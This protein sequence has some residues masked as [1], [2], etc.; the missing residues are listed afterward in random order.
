MLDL[1]MPLIEA[2]QGPRPP[3]GPN[4]PKDDDERQ[5]PAQQAQQ[6]RQKKA[7]SKRR[8]I[9]KPTPQAAAKKKTAAIAKA[10]KTKARKAKEAT[11]AALAANKKARQE[12]KAA[13]A[14]AKQEPTGTKAKATPVGKAPKEMVPAQIRHCMLALKHKRGKSEKAAWNIC[15]WAMTKYGYLKGPYRVNTKLPK[16][17]RQTQ[18][19]VRRSFQHG[20]EKGPLNKGI[21][22]T[23]ITKARKFDKLFKKIEKDVVRKG[24]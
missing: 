16:A 12:K 22:G 7:A 20:M 8:T 4:P 19:G 23:G 14:A 24:A 13:R 1:L 18:K 5:E 9:K 6:K 17:T 11:R 3:E 10:Q 15:R 21:P 2:P